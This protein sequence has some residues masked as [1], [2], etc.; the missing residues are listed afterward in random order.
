MLRNKLFS[1][2]TMK[3]IRQWLEELPEPYKSV[4]LRNAEDD[5]SRAIDDNVEHMSVALSRG[6]IWRES[7][8]GSAFWRSVFYHYL[9]STPLPPYPSH[10][11]KT[12]EQTIEEL[13]ANI[14][15][16]QAQLEKLEGGV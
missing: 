4:A 11:P 2:I 10:L 14:A 5:V 1:K 13:K 6:F 9:T 8:E 12:K 15:A 3:T 16:M 7:P